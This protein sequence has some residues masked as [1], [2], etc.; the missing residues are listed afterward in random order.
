M[1]YRSYVPAYPLSDFVETFWLAT[2]DGNSVTASRI[3]PHGAVEFV[4]SLD[5][6]ALSFSVA[7][8]RQTVKAPMWA[9]PYSKSFL[10]DPS[11]FTNVA[12]VRFKPGKARA[13]LPVPAHE[14]HNSDAPLEAFC[15]RDAARLT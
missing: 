14:L 11:E 15:P 3:V 7:G 5:R 4:I 10:I 12:G 1:P 9:G 8:T 6:P 2:N 13:F